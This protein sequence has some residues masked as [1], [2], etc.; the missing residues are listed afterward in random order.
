M[1]FISLRVC[2]K[3]C[4]FADCRFRRAWLR[5]RIAVCGGGGGE[6]ESGRRSM[7]RSTRTGGV[8]VVGLVIA[9]LMFVVAAQAAVPANTSLPSVSGS[10]AACSCS[11]WRR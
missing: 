4:S 7:M 5:L 2:L 1:S 9:A 3:L 11:W 6:S 8:L 10:F